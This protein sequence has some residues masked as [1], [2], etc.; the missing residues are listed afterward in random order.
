[1][2]SPTRARLLSTM[3]FRFPDPP[4]PLPSSG[5]VPV[6][7]PMV[8]AVNYGEDYTPTHLNWRFPSAAAEMRTWTPVIPSLRHRIRLDRAPLWRWRP[9]P[10]LAPFWNNPAGRI[11]WGRGNKCLIGRGGGWRYPTIRVNYQY[12]LPEVP[13]KLLTF[14]ADPR[15][16]NWLCL[17]YYANGILAY[18]PLVEG[19][20]K[21]SFIFQWMQDIEVMPGLG[22]WRKLMH[23]PPNTVICNLERRPGQGGSICRAAGSKAVVLPVT[24]KLV[25]TNYVPVLLPSRVVKLF[26]KECWSTVGSIAAGSHKDEQLGKAGANRNLGWRPVV[27]GVAMKPYA[28]PHGGHGKG[29]PKVFFTRW[30]RK[31]R[32]VGRAD[33]NAKKR[34][35][36]YLRWRWTAKVLERQQGSAGKTLDTTRIRLPNPNAMAWRVHNRDLK[37]NQR[38]APM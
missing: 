37:Q 7:S 4:K 29:K 34:N 33:R 30:K 35:P 2:L 32:K 11:L 10:W 13:K 24:G 1:M 31:F 5:A 6:G 12:T 25:G 16:S 26:D 23:V 17:V 18:H 21:G 19:L 3:N 9:L 38:Y 14:E 15:R 36:Y 20:Q 8:T 28:H 22:E 27:S